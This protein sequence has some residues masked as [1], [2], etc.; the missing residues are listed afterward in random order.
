[1]TTISDSTTTIYEVFREYWPNPSFGL[2]DVKG[3]FFKYTWGKVDFFFL[4]GRWYRDPDEDP[5]TPNKTMLGAAQLEWLE[6]ELDSSSA[7]FKVLVS[8]GGWSKAKGEFGDSWAGFLH[9]RNRLFDFIRDR[10]ITGVVLLS[11]DSHIGEL[12]VIGRSTSRAATSVWSSSSWTT[13]R[14]WSSS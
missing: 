11:G 8:G 9:E 10:D 2:S 1:M 3:I 4:D 14:G 7:V 5:N 6:K 13:T 12:N